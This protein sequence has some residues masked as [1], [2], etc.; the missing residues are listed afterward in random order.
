MGERGEG[1]V[2]EDAVSAFEVDGVEEE[3]VCVGQAE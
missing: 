2:V 3:G 1:E